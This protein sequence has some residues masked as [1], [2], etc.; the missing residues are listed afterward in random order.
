[1]RDTSIDR[2]EAETAATES[3]GLR[4]ANRRVAL[5]IVGGM[6]VL[7]GITLYAGLRSMPGRRA[8]DARDPMAYLP[9]DSNLVAMIEVSKVLQ[10]E[11]GNEVFNDFRLGG[12]GIAQIERWS[13]LARKEIGVLVVASHV[14]QRAI[15]RTV[16]VMETL[17]P[18]PHI[19][20]ARPQGAAA[21]E[22]EVRS[23]LSTVLRGD[24]A[25]VRVPGEPGTPSAYLWCAAETIFVIALD[26]E[27]FDAVPDEP[28]RGLDYL[29]R[30]LCR[31]LIDRVPKDAEAFVAAHGKSWN[32][33]SLSSYVERFMG[34][35][36]SESLSDFCF[37]ARFDKKIDLG[38]SCHLASRG[39]GA[40]L[41]KLLTSEHLSATATDDGWLN[42]SA[43]MSAHDLQSYWTSQPKR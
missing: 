15:P 6:L 9:A 38:G 35:Q 43:Q 23:A 26:P 24:K 8:R 39:E 41:S 7:A 29:D 16:L 20:R 37:W 27:D 10:D 12:I 21:K 40:Q 34:V 5:A 36:F 28:H 33:T 19:Q 13:G 18:H 4:A 11:A 17:H 3:P 42:I 2:T 30:D 22:A 14:D 1:M 31:L 25:L 32:K